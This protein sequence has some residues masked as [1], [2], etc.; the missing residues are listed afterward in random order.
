[1]KITW[2]GHSAFRVEIGESI[3]PFLTANPNFTAHFRASTRNAT[4]IL[5][6]H[7]H[8]DH[9][10]D[11]VRIA[12][13]TG[14]EI[15]ANFDLC[16]WLEG[17]GAKKINP[18]DTGG[19]IPCGN[20]SVSITDARHSASTIVAG[21]PVYLGPANGLVVE[22]AEELYHMGNTGIFGDMALIAE[23]YAPKSASS[24]R[25]PLHDGRRDGG[26]GGQTLF[27][28]ET[29]IP[30]HYGAFDAPA[31]TPPSLSRRCKVRSD[32]PSAPVIARSEA[33]R[34]SRGRAQLLDCFAD[35]RNDGG[36]HG[37]KQKFRQGFYR[38]ANCL[39]QRG[40]LLGCED[41]GCRAEQIIKR[42]KKAE[43]AENVTAFQCHAPRAGFG[44]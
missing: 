13:E 33:T 31:P 39:E 5:L 25:R 6:T 2:L 15:V 24:R 1:M 30:C 17:Q 18:G 41:R 21:A 9:I 28:F 4:H 20:F 40:A 26:A 22:S 42:D 8:D 43:R 12:E 10:G 37:L 32:V 7:G 29:V 16:V 35:A 23:L 44:R 27:A 36:R 34:Q 19:K 11:T 14:A 3:I 38:F